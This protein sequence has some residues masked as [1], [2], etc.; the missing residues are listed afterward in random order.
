[1]RA[2]TASTLLDWG[3]VRRPRSSFR[4]THSIDRVTLMKWRGG[5]EHS[6]VG[7]NCIGV[8]K[9][10][11]LNCTLWYRVWIRKRRYMEVTCANSILDCKILK[12]ERREWMDQCD[13]F[14]NLND[15]CAH[16]HHQNHSKIHFF[17]TNFH[18]EFWLTSQWLSNTH[19]S[20]PLDFKKYE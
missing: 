12:C 4:S 1:M 14:G 17:R 3:T 2:T 19:D 18:F 20:S 16:L 6:I 8:S 7:T 13:N 15:E 10:E 11:L 9:A 5:I